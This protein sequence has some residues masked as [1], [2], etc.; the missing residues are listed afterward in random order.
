MT[1]TIILDGNTLS[2]EEVVEVAR[3]NKKVQISKDQVEKIKESRAFVEEAVAKK[4]VIYGIT[5][6]FGRFSDVSI[7]EED[8]ST[9]QR[10]LIISHATGV[11]RPFD[12]EVV[13]AML[14][15]RSNALIKG[16]SGVELSTIETM[17]DMLN[18]G[19]HPQIMSQGSVGSSGDL[20]PLA[21]MVLPMIGEGEAEYKGQILAGKDAMGKA[22]IET[23]EL[24][25]KEGLGLINGTQAMTANAV[26]AVYDGERLLKEADI[27]G[28][29]SFEALEGVIDA[30][31][32]RVQELRP[33]QGQIDV[34]ENFRKILEGSK[35]ATRQGEKRVQDAY[36]IR[37]IPQVH[38]GSREA[39]TYV[40]SIIET[41]INSVTDNPL[42]FTDDNPMAISGGNF[43]GQPVAIAMDVLSILVSEIGNIS[44]RRTAKLVDPSQSH[45]LPGFLAKDGGLNSGFMIPQYVAAAL[46]SENK[47]LAHPASVDSVPTSANQEDHVSMGTI[48]AR[49]ARE[50]LINVQNILGIELICACQGIDFRGSEN[51]ASGTKAAYDRLRQD[52][53]FQDIDVVMYPEVHKAQD[54]IKDHSI[55]EA[56][57]E[58]IGSLK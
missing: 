14:V 19:V 2:V 17:V 5:T 33:H 50:I 26:L 34:A 57:E 35:L 13:R 8:T 15:L 16:Y 48:G 18:K 22:G 37:C 32:P 58:E 45:G 40:K 53:K 42:I 52:V 3:F 56:V 49:Q 4:E 12:R 51:L 25:A 20:A 43:H 10:N 44:E 31:D 55:L 23:I 54:M 1:D 28:S 24:S 21:H 38:G 39:F 7:S 36:S 41:E 47:V 29:L 30:F 11:G 46:V 6:G 27:I 9:L